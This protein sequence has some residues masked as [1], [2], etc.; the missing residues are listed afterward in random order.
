MSCGIDLH[1][2]TPRREEVCEVAWD[3]THKHQLP[4]YH[5]PAPVCD[6]K[7]RYQHAQTA[8]VMTA[9]VGMDEWAHTECIS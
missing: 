5:T 7:D 2:H 8:L 1:L 9:D 3:R 4:A 6:R